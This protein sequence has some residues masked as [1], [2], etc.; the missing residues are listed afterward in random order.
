MWARVTSMRRGAP[1]EC[2]Q[3]AW[4]HGDPRVR[5]DPVNSRCGAGVRREREPAGKPERPHERLAPRDRGG[6]GQQGG[7]IPEGRHAATMQPRP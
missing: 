7:G 6:S 1:A 2:P 3:L 5:D 4:T